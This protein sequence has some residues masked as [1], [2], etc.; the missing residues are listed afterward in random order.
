MLAMCDVLDLAISDT[1]NR[2]LLNRFEILL[3]FHV[4]SQL[5]N[6]GRNIDKRIYLVLIDPDAAFIRRCL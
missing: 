6:I 2:P 5:S 1:V 3:D 4:I